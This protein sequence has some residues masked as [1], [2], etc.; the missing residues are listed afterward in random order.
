MGLKVLLLDRQAPPEVTTS[1]TEVPELRVSTVTP[2]SVQLFKDIGAW[3][4]IAPP[5]SA[6]F[7]KMQVCGVI[8]SL[9]INLVSL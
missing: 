3:E 6:A 7:K 8:L 4:H 2:A 9:Q 1:L 5:R